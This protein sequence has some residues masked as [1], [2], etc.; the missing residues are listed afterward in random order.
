MPDKIDTDIF[1][2]PS[3]L[4]TELKSNHFSDAGNC[5]YFVH[6][7][8]IQLEAPPI[9]F[10]GG[11]LR[12]VEFEEWSKLDGEAAQKQLK[13]YKKTKPIFYIRN[14]ECSSTT[15]LLNV[16]RD[17][18][19]LYSILTIAVGMRMDPP[20]ASMTYA[21][22]N[23]SIHRTIGIQERRAIVHGPIKYCIRADAA[24]HLL[25]IL[26]EYNALG[27]AFELPEIARVVRVCGRPPSKNVELID[28]IMRL[29]WALEALLLKDITT[30]ITA[31][32]V[33]RVSKVILRKVE[34][35]EKLTTELNILYGLR[36]DALHGR[37]WSLSIAGTGRDEAGWAVR[38]HE[39]LLR[40]TNALIREVGSNNNPRKALDAFC[41]SLN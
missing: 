8:N 19:L 27:A 30:G 17:A 18:K 16:Q 21:A 39:I 35:A 15:T 41:G 12:Q 26:N 10:R 40:A 11:Q 31:N 36:S 22:R 9:Q 7:P 28:D 14:D 37:D 4:P 25:T 6:L 33:S 24:P 3:W 20:S 23:G 29:T 2:M 1:D 13:Y 5:S 32:F 34:L 38:A